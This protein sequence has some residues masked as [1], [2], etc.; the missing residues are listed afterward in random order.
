MET[1]AKRSNMEEMWYQHQRE[2]TFQLLK[3]CAMQQA[4]RVVYLHGVI[5]DGNI[6]D[7]T[8]VNILQSLTSAAAVLSA[9][10]DLTLADREALIERYKAIDYSEV[11]PLFR[12]KES[13]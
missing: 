9:M 5:E 10:L 3:A 4:G 8:L 7:F 11:H 12:S 13:E 6:E 2:A 1:T